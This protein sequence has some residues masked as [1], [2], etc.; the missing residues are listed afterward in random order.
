MM[1]ETIWELDWTN[2]LTFK[3]GETNVTLL[4]IARLSDSKFFFVLKNAEAVSLQALL[5][6][7]FEGIAGLSVPDIPGPWGKLLSE[8]LCIEISVSPS[9]KKL[10]G[11]LTYLTPVEIKFI[12]SLPPILKVYGVTLSISRTD[13]F[14]FGADIEI[15][16]QPRQLVE[17]PLPTPAPPLPPLLQ[18]HYLA[19]GQRLQVAANPQ[20]PSIPDVI[21]RLKQDLSPENPSQLA[22]AFRKY[23]KP[24]AGWL[25]AI[26]LEI[27]NFLSLQVIFN[28]PSLYGL[29]ITLSEKLK[30]KGL[31]FQILYTKVNDEIGMFYID[32]TLPD[33]VRQF[34]VGAASITLPSVDITIYTNGDFRVAIGWPLGGRSMTVQVIVPPGIPL[35]GG[36]GFYFA[37]LSGATA[38]DMPPPPAGKEWGLILAFGIAMRLG[39]GKEIKKGILSAS[40]SVT[41]FGIFEGRIAWLDEKSLDLARQPSGAFALAPA[42]GIAA[43]AE[44][45]KAPSYF[46]FRGTFG[47][48]A[49]IEG[50]IDFTIIKASLSIRLEASI[51]VTFETGRDIPIT[52][53]GRVSVSLSV[54][55]GGFKIFGVRIAIVIKF[56]FTAEISETFVIP[57]KRSAN[58]FLLEAAQLRPLGWGL[59]PPLAAEPE[60]VTLRIYF[61]PQLSV[62]G[63]NALYLAG[64]TIST[65]DFEI[66]VRKVGEF[67]LQVAATNRGGTDRLTLRDLRLIG[68]Q[69]GMPRWLNSR[70]ENDDPL[71]YEVIIRNLERLKVTLLVAGSPQGTASQ[72]Q[73]IFPMIPDLKLSVEGSADPPPSEVNF[74]TKTPRSETFI[75][76]LKDY[77]SELML[78]FGN[79]GEP[80]RSALDPAL[81]PSMATLI[82]E[83]YFSQIFKEM[84]EQILRSVERQV[85]TARE[86]ENRE[87]EIQELLGEV[88]FADLAG[89]VSRFL[90]QGLRLPS[91]ATIPPDKRQWPDLDLAGLYELTGQEFAIRLRDGVDYV[92][93]LGFAVGERPWLKLGT[94]AEAPVLIVGKDDGDA[95]QKLKKLAGLAMQANVI[96]PPTPLPWIRQRPLAF[97]LKNS[98]V[99]QRETS[100]SKRRQ[101]RA[102]G[103]PPRIVSLAGPLA[104]RVSRD[105][106]VEFSQFGLLTESGGVTPMDY[107]TSVRI[108]LSV[109]RVLRP[110]QTNVS[111][112]GE[113]ADFLPNVYQ[114]GG[115]DEANRKVLQSLLDEAR[116]QPGL[117]DQIEDIALLY[118]SG[119]D[120]GLT[121]RPTGSSVFLIKTNLSTDS[122]PDRLQAMLRG[123]AEEDEN[124]VYARLKDRHALLL[125]LIQCS[126]VNSGGYY[127]HYVTDTGD[128]L[129]A[130]LFR[131]SNRSP[132]TIVITFN[133]SVK[134]L[135]PFNNA[136]VATSNPGVAVVKEETGPT[137]RAEIRDA[138]EYDPAVPAGSVSFSL[139]R[140]NPKQGYVL[141]N[142]M[143]GR[144]LTRR[145][146]EETLAAR[147]IGRDHPDFDT[148]MTEAGEMDVE[149]AKLF[150]S[151][152]FRIQDTEGIHRSMWSIPLGPVLEQGDKESRALAERLMREPDAEF[153]WRYTHT[154]AYYRFAQ[155][156]FD[157]PEVRPNRYLGIG[158]TLIANFRVVDNYGD[159]LTHSDAFPPLT[160]PKLLYYDRLLAITEWPGMAVNFEVNRPEQ[161]PS[162]ILVVTLTLAP[163]SF[164]DNGVTTFSD[165]RASA[166]AEYERIADQLTDPN[167]RATFSTTLTGDTQTRIDLA[168]LAEF[169]GRIQKYLRGEVPSVAP[170]LLPFTLTNDALAHQTA[171]IFKLTAAI[172][173]FRDGNVAPETDGKIPEAREV[174]TQVPAKVPQKPAVEADE[175]LQ[176]QEIS[177]FAQRFEA[178]FDR[179]LRIALGTPLAAD[180]ASRPADANGIADLWVIRVG[181]SGIQVTF[182]PSL[183]HYYA[184]APLSRSLQSNVVTVREYISGPWHGG[185]E[186]YTE[187]KRGFNDEDIDVWASACLAAIDAFLSPDLSVAVAQVAPG[188]FQEIMKQKEKLAAEIKKGLIPVLADDQPDARAQEAAREA[189][190]QRI[191]ITLASAY[192]VNAV[193]QVPARVK[194]HGDV[195]EAKLFGPVKDIALIAEDQPQSNSF[196]TGRLPLADPESIAASPA[197]LSGVQYL[198][199]LFT[200]ADPTRQTNYQTSVAYDVTYVEHDFAPLDRTGDDAPRYVTSSWLKLVQPFGDAA[201]NIEVDIP[202]PLRFYPPVPL[203]KDQRADAK[204]NPQSSDARFAAATLDDPI[205]KEVTEWTYS[206]AYDQA[207]IAQDTVTAEVTFNAE[208]RPEFALTMTDRVAAASEDRD[209]PRSLFEALARFTAESPAIAAHYPA[210]LRA[211]NEGQD[212]QGSGSGH[213]TFR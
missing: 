173:L 86:E 181:E 130:D 19:L 45:S 162:P 154:F 9:Q 90:Q 44:F 7:L 195:V 22:E 91:A 47:I 136:V 125:L 203:L 144:D 58:S 62:G 49:V 213:P 11:K 112:E 156:N 116:R 140:K 150:N 25:V 46:W 196:S 87:W 105:G 55:I 165:T 109:R 189:F 138:F 16:G 168:I 164:S 26:D 204:F 72:D 98:I 186:D 54:E 24:E 145:Q 57:G 107:R 89:K 42:N 6:K 102:T 177:L 149:I 40:I 75:R 80:P 160:V 21:N 63:G 31:K 48:T 205:L 99:W 120:Q 141:P 201:Q 3:V 191:L 114:L 210:I 174:I 199:F 127:L 4:L 157:K 158:R 78:A 35:I 38:P 212:T 198:T 59:S 166:L 8:G 13:G 131:D 64:L 61:T 142:R 119:E 192:Q 197:S 194:H 185:P 83:D 153:P 118:P 179:K 65:A 14:D 32:L 172:R 60:P 129:P 132:F 176:L 88:N 79:S 117:L 193:V 93:R 82:F 171:E 147:G 187:V 137:Y 134:T 135:F 167:T 182:E 148:L 124:P 143:G 110:R 52:V 103:E 77:I 163:D 104:A 100:V 128:D 69:L 188:Q 207:I 208:A 76:E 23:Y 43:L 96:H 41:F 33:I 121:S 146:L 27:R 1:A 74:L 126:I 84:H 180:R 161:A 108:D 159:I 81:E 12:E 183:R 170:L 111:S 66:L 17:Y 71:T 106:R 39:V 184:P 123:A 97:T 68:I 190:F 15:F 20:N 70:S 152:Q 29:A 133:K 175:E 169:V 94:G 113:P 200:A 34:E 209:P 122:N 101:A 53:G 5:N 95:R 206:F 50:A 73:V 30:L 28:D 155:E 36:G 2:K 10:Q 202:I 56:S 139:E 51:T 85:E 211:A 67:L 151:V 92:V 115:A 18:F 37:K 178:A